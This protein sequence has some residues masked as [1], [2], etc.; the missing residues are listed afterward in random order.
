[1]CEW[2]GSGDLV[3]RA[4]VGSKA[5]VPVVIFSESTYFDE[6]RR[7]SSEF[8]KSILITAC[9]A[10]LVG[11]TPHADYIQQL[12]M[13]EQCIF[14]G[15]NVVDNEHFRRKRLYHGQFKAQ[16]LEEKS[17]FL[18][19]ARLSRKKNIP[20]IIK[21][22]Y[23]YLEE[24][25]R[26]GVEAFDLKIVGDGELRSEIQC[27]ID[28]YQVAEQAV[29]LGAVDY[30]S[31]PAV[32]HN[33]TA[34]IHASTTEQWGLVVNEA[35]AAGLPVLISHSVG[36]AKD[37][38]IDGYNGIYFDPLST[39]SLTDTLIQYSSLSGA[40]RLEMGARSQE[41]I[42]SWSPERYGQA[43]ANA[44]RKAIEVGPKRY[45]WLQKLILGTLLK[46]G[47]E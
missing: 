14:T 25:K 24:C 3:D 45:S 36:C 5:L 22:Y 35:M 20:N 1:M 32:Y 2:V 41:M 9:A 34:L 15:H 10:A 29:I 33:A 38:V 18:V 26:I 6:T 30:D 4:L 21:G 42:A 44:V 12:G 8:V 28:E 27:L 47:A 31:L 11:G 37:L 39:S 17:Y 46:R 43:L 13:R 7:F 19:C 40:D 23:A 16:V